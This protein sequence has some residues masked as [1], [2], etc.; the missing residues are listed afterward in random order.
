[1]RATAKSLRPGFP[2]FIRNSLR[3][4]GS[5]LDSPAAGNAKT[6]KPVEGGRQ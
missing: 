6:R 3:V 4:S 5:Q 1:M 2:G